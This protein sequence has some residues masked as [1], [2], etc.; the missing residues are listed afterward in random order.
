[1]SLPK[2]ASVAVVGGGVIGASV[3][4]HLAANGVRDVVVLDRA[5]G[6]GN[7]STGA[8]TGGFRAQYGTAVNVRLSLLSRA[9]LMRFEEETGV[10]PGY[11]QVGYLWLATSEA[12]LESL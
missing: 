4:H 5:E 12:A 9:L 2:H 1:M 3:A 8:A 7:G 6:P 11:E 10:D